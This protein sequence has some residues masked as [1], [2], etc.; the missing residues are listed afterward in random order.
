MLPI[1]TTFVN[2]YR[3]KYHKKIIT[4]QV[5]QLINKK[6]NGNSFEVWKIYWRSCPL[7]VGIIQRNLASFNYKILQAYRILD[8]SLNISYN[9][10]YG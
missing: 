5:W 6:A 1:R 10:I 9:I 2:S 4:I 7:T 3:K 8:F